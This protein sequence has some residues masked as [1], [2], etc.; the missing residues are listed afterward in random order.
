MTTRTIR[1]AVAADVPALA[2]LTE[3][4]YAPHAARIGMR[5]APMDADHAADVAAGRV[6]V[7]DG[8]DA[9]AAAIVLADEP[10]HL[11]VESVA[12]DPAAQGGGLGR[13]LMLHAE[14]QARARGHA[15][16]R[17]YTNVLMTANVAWYPRLGYEET[18]RR[19][20]DG[21]ARVFF[22]KRLS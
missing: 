3:A 21:F 22:R 11:L 16:V 7:V 13:R 20:E 15:E 5:P 2:R 19:E 17:L 1:R 14:E 9:P 18:E 4:A 8:E 6:W 12:V 10:G